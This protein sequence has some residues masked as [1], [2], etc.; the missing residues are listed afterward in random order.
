MCSVYTLTT[1]VSLLR[2]M[3]QAGLASD[4]AKAW[5]GLLAELQAITGSA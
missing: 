3:L 2:C 5:G 4:G 1:A